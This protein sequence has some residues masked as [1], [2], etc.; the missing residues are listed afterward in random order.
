MAT[1]SVKYPINTDVEHFTG[2]RGRV[3]AIFLRKGHRSYEMSYLA[4]DKPTCCN[5]E[6]GE[7]SLICAGKFGFKKEKEND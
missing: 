1:V 4:D 5:V 3:T 2:I 6:E 7:I